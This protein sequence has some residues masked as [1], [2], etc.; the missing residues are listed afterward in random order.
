MEEEARGYKQA[1]EEE[2][3]AQKKAVKA[4]EGAK[5]RVETQLSEQMRVLRKRWPNLNG[6]KATGKQQSPCG[7]KKPKQ[8]QP[9]PWRGKI[10]E[11]EAAAEKTKATL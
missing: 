5:N 3:E 4:A 1:A 8:R 2:I 6:R 7:S 10:K 11:L 9:E